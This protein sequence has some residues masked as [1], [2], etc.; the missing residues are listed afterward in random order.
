MDGFGDP[1][2]TQEEIAGRLA[3]AKF[4]QYLGLNP[5]FSQALYQ[6]RRRGLT[7][8]AL[9]RLQGEMA[10]EQNLAA[11]DAAAARP[12]VRMGD[13]TWERDPLTPAQAWQRQASG[14][15]FGAPSWAP[16][17]PLLDAAQKAR[18]RENLP[19][20]VQARVDAGWTDGFAGQPG[21]TPPGARSLMG[22]TRTE[23]VSAA[24][25]MA[26]SPALQRYASL[27]DPAQQAAARQRAAA[28]AQATRA[29]MPAMGRNAA[30]ELYPTAGHYGEFAG[31]MTQLGLPSDGIGAS[32]PV[33]FQDALL[34]AA[35]KAGRGAPVPDVPIA[36]VQ[37]LRAKQQ[38]FA[39]AAHQKREEE[40]ASVKR[41]HELALKEKENQGKVDAAAMQGGGADKGAREDYRQDY[42]QAMAEARRYEKL[43][44][45]S[46]EG[47]T[48]DGRYMSAEEVQAELG[49]LRDR[50]GGKPVPP[51][52]ADWEAQWAERGV[53]GF[54]APAP[55]VGAPAAAPASAPPSA[56]PAGPSPAQG[57]TPSASRRPEVGAQMPADVRAQ[58][59]A[60]RARGP[61]AVAQARQ[62]I[63]G[64]TLPPAEKRAAL[65]VLEGKG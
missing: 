4:Q 28:Q 35:R 52:Y 15:S 51:N 38:G 36:E 26:A 58:L 47:G 12:G 14:M 7:P 62:Q 27:L 65:A 44:A 16:M 61:A 20:D 19:P 55:A 37:E 5:A 30:G 29:A 18:G 9:E 56:S 39:A 46:S 60:V 23:S 42:R 25:A 33:T 34:A 63:Q 49:V 45:V 13:R 57:A 32:G 6:L 10:H 2:A 24:D 21:A 48:V 43:R 59:E 31:T 40:A 11:V 54:Q 53:P 64:S 3:A 22:P 8:E 50:Y 17:Q 1:N 41:K